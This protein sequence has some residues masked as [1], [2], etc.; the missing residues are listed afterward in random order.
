MSNASAKFASGS[1]E[2]G[3]HCY[4]VRVYYED[5]DAGG[6][7]YHSKYLNYAERARTEMLRCHGIAQ[8]ALRR[9]EGVVF[10]VRDC[11]VTFQR[12]ARFDDLL[13]VQTEVSSFTG[14]SLTMAQ[15]IT[16][17]SETLVTLEFRIAAVNDR[18]RATRLP[19]S[20]KR[21]FAHSGAEPTDDQ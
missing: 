17:D 15:T 10:A 7:V 16:R 3:H 4:A 9:D 13:E 6:I 2:N 20:L 19:Q 5:T 12:P 21:A 11:R 14:A 1:L 8:S 18:G